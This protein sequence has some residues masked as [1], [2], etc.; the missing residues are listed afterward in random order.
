M[1]LAATVFAA[2]GLALGLSAASV[3]PAA[4]QV[5]YTI[6]G[7]VPPPNIQMYM[8]MNQLPPGHYWLDQNGYWGVMGN[9]TPLG[10]IYAGQ[11]Q[12]QQGY[13][14]QYVSPGGSGQVNPDGSWSHYTENPT[15]SGGYGVGGTSDGCIYTP[16]WSNC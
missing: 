16:D 7:Q 14:G 10:N 8:A 4:A 9:T 3:T 12:Q 5:Y 1:K 15:G 2:L 13:T 11:Q 6:N